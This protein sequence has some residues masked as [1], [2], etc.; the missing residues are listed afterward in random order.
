MNRFAVKTSSSIEISLPGHTVQQGDHQGNKH[1]L[2]REISFLDIFAR[3]AK[4]SDMNG[5]LEPESKKY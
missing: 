2:V 1:S 3:F 4:S 5:K